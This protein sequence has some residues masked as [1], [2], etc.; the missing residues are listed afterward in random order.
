VTAV[1]GSNLQF[2]SRS[3]SWLRRRRK[4][5]RRWR[6]IKMTTPRSKRRK[7][8]YAATVVVVVVRCSW[9]VVCDQ[10][11]IRVT[12]KYDVIE[13]N[14]RKQCRSTAATTAPTVADVSRMRKSTE[15]GQHRP[16][17]L[18]DRDEQVEDP[19]RS[20][21][22]QHMTNN[23]TVQDHDGCRAVQIHRRQQRRR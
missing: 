13:R 9:Y 7:S 8:S 20:T 10:L 16:C 11:S 5:P 15:I 4:R 14:Y 17:H 3:I 23:A 18:A 22:R 6:N 1:V 2:H 19:P 12:P 21:A